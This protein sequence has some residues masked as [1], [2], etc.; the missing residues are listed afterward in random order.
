VPSTP[1]IPQASAPLLAELA[2]IGEVRAQLL[3]KLGLR[4]PLD[5][6]YHTP[7]RYED[8]ARFHLPS[9]AEDGQAITV[10]GLVTA[11]KLARWRGGRRVFEIHLELSHTQPLETLRAFWFNSWFPPKVLIKGV[12]AIFHGRLKKTAKGHS[13]FHPEFELMEHDQE[14]FIHLSRLTPIYSLTEG[15][16]QRVLRRILFHFT[17]RH[18]LAFLTETYPLPPDFLPLTEALRLIHFPKTWSSQQ[19]ARRRLVFDEFFI[20]QCLLGRRRRQRARLKKERCRPTATLTEAFLTSLPFPPTQAQ[21]RSM[22]EIDTDLRVETPM[23]RLLQGD[24]GSGKTLVAVHAM[25][26]A[27]EQGE[28]A[29]LMAPTEILA[30]QHYLNLRRWLGPL[31]ISVGLH[32]ANKKSG[33]RSP[34]DSKGVQENLFAG[35]GAI[36]IGTHALLYDSFISTNLGL[37]V[38]DEQHKFGVRQRLAFSQKGRAPDILVMTATPIPR[39]LAMTVYGDLDVSLLDELPPGRGKIITACRSETA[40]PKVWQFMR[41]QLAAGRQAYVVYPLIEESEKIDAKAVQAEFEKLTTLFSGFRVGLLHGRLSPADKELVMREFRENKVQLL[42]STPVIEV[43]VDV[44]NATMMVIENAER[45]GLAQL[46]QLRGRVGRGGNKSYCVLVGHPKSEESW[47]RLKIM[48]ATTDGFRIAEEDLKIRGPGD[49]LGTEQSGLPPLRFGDPLVDMD[50]LHLAKAHA[51]KILNQDPSLKK[52][53]GLKATLAG[54]GLGRVS[55]A[56]VS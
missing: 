31:N 11:A 13:L 20:Q 15:L 49:I 53:P 43:G 30:E 23:N 12:E 50:L 41:E 19:Q 24:V 6:L 4:T 25:L 9:T 18:D 32:T 38:I 42:V 51:E 56:T 26:R 8:R 10:R 37:I 45:F 54:T 7:H 3:H 28:H 22:R 5:L 1:S 2:G 29:A 47:R 55:L 44:P 52:Y 33:D 17:Q 27:V 16:S 39:T 21:S 34:L 35:R 36:T 48:E 46:H 40:L 14:E